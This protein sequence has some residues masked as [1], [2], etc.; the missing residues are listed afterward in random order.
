MAVVA[1]RVLTWMSKENRGDLGVVIFWAEQ[2]GYKVEFNNGF[3]R[4]LMELAI[5]ATI[6]PHIVGFRMIYGF[7]ETRSI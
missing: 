2:H 1:L 3:E 7:W 4:M 6:L 5:L